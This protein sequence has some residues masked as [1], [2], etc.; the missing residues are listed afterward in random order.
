MATLPRWRLRAAL[1]IGCIWALV[2]LP[3]GALVALYAAGSSP[4]PEDLL[5]RPVEVPTFLLVWTIWGGL[6]GTGFAII[7]GTAERRRTLG[8]LSIARTGLWGALGAMSAPTLLTAVD[9]VRGLLGASLY[10]WRV[11]FVSVLASAILGGACGAAT[12]I[13]ARRGGP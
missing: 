12:L 7:L 1:A 13:A 5:Y 3:L 11:P 9:M 4:Q 8:Q 10:D 6:S 2:W